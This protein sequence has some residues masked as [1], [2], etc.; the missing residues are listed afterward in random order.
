MNYIFTDIFYVDVTF[1]S[2]HL[3]I[4]SAVSFSTFL[5]KAININESKTC[6]YD[7]NLY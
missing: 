5:A 6:Q 3:P 1:G 4:P 7:L 2:F